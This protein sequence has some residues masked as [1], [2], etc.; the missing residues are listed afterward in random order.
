M[1][2]ATLVEQEMIGSTIV[3]LRV[4]PDIGVPAF[5]PGQ[6]FAIGLGSEGDFVQ[7]PYST[8]S[9]RGEADAL[10]FL[11][12]LVPG[13]AL[14]PRLFG[15][16]TGARL[17]L[18]APKGL[19]TAD[20]DDPRQPLLVGTGTGIAPLLSILET[21]LRESPTGTATPL[22]I[23]IHGASFVGDLAGRSRLSALEA[24]GAIAYVP[25]VSRVSD[26][27]NAGWGGAA[28]RLDG[29]LPEVLADNG[30]DP[31]MTLAYVCGNPLLVAAAAGVLLGLGVPADAIRTEAW[32]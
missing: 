19:F 7:R 18:G 31:A 10:E 11:V 4:R 13:G 12:R 28:G 5:R 15:L 6:Y 30:V 8:S 17:R 16:A 32:S 26:I 14:T 3:R 29:L 20:S 2:N 1:P 23:V 22:P 25:A 9:A 27:A 24:A 21:R